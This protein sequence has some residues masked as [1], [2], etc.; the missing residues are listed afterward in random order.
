MSL[1]L[2]ISA[3]RALAPLASVFVREGHGD[4]VERALNSI[5]TLAERGEEAFGELSGLTTRLQQMEGVDRVE[6]E[7]LWEEIESLH[8]AIQAAAKLIPPDPPAPP[9]DPPADGGTPPA[10][11]SGGSGEGNQS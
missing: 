7:R 2:V 11:E 6:K 10:G 4:R 3:L 1:T 8:A 5:A 9:A